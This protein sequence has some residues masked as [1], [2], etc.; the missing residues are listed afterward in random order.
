[1]NREIKKKEVWRIISLF[2]KYSISNRGRI[3]RMDTGKY[4]KLRHEKD[5]LAYVNIT[6]NEG[7]CRHLSVAYLLELGKFAEDDR[8]AASRKALLDFMKDLESDPYKSEATL[9]DEED[10]RVIP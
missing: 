4:L 10:L 8:K 6:D 1:M 7:R 5:G 3:L 2:P 9:F